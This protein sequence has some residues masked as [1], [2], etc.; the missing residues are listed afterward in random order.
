[1]L[2]PRYRWVLPE[3]ADPDPALVAAAAAHELSPRLA[4]LLARR[5]VEGPE[6]LA[7]FFGHPEASLHDPALLPD[8]ALLGE[9]IRRARR[10]G[11]GI[12]VFGDF[13]ADGLTGL[14]IVTSA[15][16]QLG[17]D[18]EPYVP[19]RLEEGHGLSRRAVDAAAA[20][21]RRLIV[22]VDTGTTSGAEIAAA[23]AAGIDVV[24]TDHHRVP[25]E[26]PPAVAVVNA[27]RRDSRYPDRRLA[28]SGIAFKVA[29]LLLADLPDGAARALDLADLAAIGTV[30]DVTPIVGENRA[31]ARIGLERLRRAPR[32]GIA[33]LLA[34]AGIAPAA[35]D[36]E[37]VGFAIAPRL[38]AAG[39]IGEAVDAARLLL[40]TDPTEAA[41]LADRLEAV[42][43]ERRELSKEVLA[44][45]RLAVVDATLA[46]AGPSA[47]VVRG[48]WPVGIVGLVAAR[49]SEETGLPAIVGAELDGVVR[50]SCRNGGPLDLAG[51]LESCGDLL[52]RHGG[53]RGAAGFEI[54]SARWDEF[55]V[56]FEALAGAVAPADPRPVLRIDLALPV[57]ELGYGLHRELGRLEPTGPGNEAPLLAV[58][59]ATVVRVRETRGGHT[60]LTLRRDR[61]VIDAIAFGR[62]DL[63]AALREG[64]L[65]DLAG[66]LESRSWGGVESLRLD[67][68]DVA[69]AGSPG[70]ARPLAGIP[71]EATVEAA[72]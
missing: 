50:A 1:M 46:G 28:G 23:A 31:I 51:A 49:L 30:A 38:N 21:G 68:R 53:H 22:T 62:D 45:A 29:Q 14:A 55:R 61:D 13:D 52:V 71:V 3:P 10:D 11:E 15:L 63:A 25:A 42:N 5:G 36:L 66:R 7:A 20:G 8:A 70:P 32:P 17:C 9:R 64:D 57:R 26:L 59:G 54:E 12:L 18:A 33:A 60:Q 24:V 39:R 69:P 48:P 44:A 72:R 56:R 47:I 2:E 16:R 67:V 19:S 34:R 35:V 65:V 58:L 41:T 43:L 37:T 4:G 40:A 6:A 27:H